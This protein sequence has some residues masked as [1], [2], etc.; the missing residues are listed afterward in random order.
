MANI[1][2]LEIS[3]NDIVNYLRINGDFS[4]AL[5]EV[6]HR[7]VTVQAAKA[8]GISVT[9]EELQKSSEAFRLAYD[10]GSADDTILWLKENGLTVENFEDYIEENILISRF[11]TLLEENTDMKKYLESEDIKEELRDMIYDNWLDETLEQQADTP[12]KI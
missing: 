7:K 4:E 10:L 2:N 3:V 12:E 6:I 8:K 1:N 9:E 11:K 5:A